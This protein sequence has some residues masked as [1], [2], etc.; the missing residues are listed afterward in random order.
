MNL[1]EVLSG[2]AFL[3]DYSAMNDEETWLSYWKDLG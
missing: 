3:L 1:R 2:F